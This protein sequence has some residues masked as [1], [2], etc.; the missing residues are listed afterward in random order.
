VYQPLVGDGSIVARAVGVQGNGFPY[1]ALMIRE[2]L[3]GSATDAVVAELPNQSYFFDRTTTGG[4]VTYQNGSFTPYPN[5]MKLTRIGNVFTAYVSPDG[6]NWT[7]TG[8]AATVAMASNV[9]IGMAACEP[10]GY[11]DTVTFDNVS[12]GSAATPAPVITGLS[13]TTGGV[14][15]QVQVAGANFGAV[16]MGVC[17]Y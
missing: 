10:Y 8:T 1:P 12:V 13:A 3:S 5:W 4:S 6:V 9:Y 11:L 14:G 7:Q 2:S 15:T 17:S 16:Q